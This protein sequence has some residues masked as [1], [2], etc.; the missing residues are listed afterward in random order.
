[1][2]AAT[3]RSLPEREQVT[4]P[5]MAVADPRRRQLGRLRLFNGRP[6]RV[7]HGFKARGD[8]SVSLTSVGFKQDFF[9]PSLGEGPIVRRQSSAPNSPN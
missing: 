7:R 1:M 8:D 2:D 4:G 5:N 9:C 3:V 6:L